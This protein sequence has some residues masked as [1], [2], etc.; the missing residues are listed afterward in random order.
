MLHRVPYPSSRWARNLVGA[1]HDKVTSMEGSSIDWA[2]PNEFRDEDGM[3][4]RRHRYYERPRGFDRYETQR[5]PFSGYTS[6]SRANNF[7]F[8][9]QCLN[10]LL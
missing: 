3:F 2:D 6:K 10:K 4:A 8:P 7:Q 5:C 9:E 1:F